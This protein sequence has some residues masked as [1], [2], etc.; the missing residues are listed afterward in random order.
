MLIQL[1]SAGLIAATLSMVNPF[2]KQPHLF[3]IEAPTT[4]ESPS[5]VLRAN[6]YRMGVEGGVYCQIPIVNTTKGAF[7]AGHCLEDWLNKKGIKHFKGQNEKGE[8]LEF[9]LVKLKDETRGLD[10]A[11][12]RASKKGTLEVGTVANLKQGDPVWLYSPKKGVSQGKVRAM[13]YH[14]PNSQ[15]A[16][17]FYITVGSCGESGSGVVDK[18]GKLI[19]IFVATTGGVNDQVGALVSI[20]ALLN[21]TLLGKSL[22]YL[23]PHDNEDQQ[24]FISQEEAESQ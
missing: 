10:Y 5:D 18:K 16:P 13:P 3:T 11:Y 23:S 17:N 6:T 1:I 14:G 24:Q 12:L 15:V 7:T 8:V 21:D 20:D 19:G 9:E 4:A 22:N 2:V